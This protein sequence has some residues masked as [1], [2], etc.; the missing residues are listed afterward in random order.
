VPGSVRI[1]T[2]SFWKGFGADLTED[3]MRKV[4]GLMDP[5]PDPIHPI[6][7]DRLLGK[8]S[9]ISR[10]PIR[11]LRSHP[12]AEFLGNRTAAERN[13][14]ALPNQF[15]GVSMVLNKLQELG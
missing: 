6:F 2:E 10:H 8:Q 13:H 1:N 5:L 11:H 12:L 15:F 14:H 7:N 4:I 3:R 9:L